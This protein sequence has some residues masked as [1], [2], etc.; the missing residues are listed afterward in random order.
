MSQAMM[1]K[2]LLYLNV[3]ILNNLLESDVD[4]TSPLVIFEGEGENE[5]DMEDKTLDYIQDPDDEVVIGAG[6]YIWLR[7]V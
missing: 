1:K 7:V 5:G 3:S 4:E 6:N 2:T